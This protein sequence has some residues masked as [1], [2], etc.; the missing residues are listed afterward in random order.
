MIEPDVVEKLKTFKNSE[1]EILSVYLGEDT[2]QA[3]TGDYLKKQFH[4]LLH[5]N[6]DKDLR[7]KFGDDINS[8]EEYLK[9]YTPSG[10]T[11]VFFSAG[12]N[13]WEVVKLEFSLPSDISLDNSPNIVPIVDALNKYSKYL[14]LLTDR[15]KTRMLLVEQGE[16]VDYSQ[17]I[18]SYVPQ[19]ESATGKGSLPSQIDVNFRHTEKLLDDRLKL[20]ADAVAKF[21]KDKDIHF[22]ILGGHKEMFKRV[23]ETLKSDLQ[24]KIV[25][26]FVSEVDLPLNQIL[27][28]SKS[29]AV[30]I[31]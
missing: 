22:I 30:K 28:K 23:A 10:R 27:F 4:S 1:F 15:E 7:A 16:I 2:V 18:G 3:P 21:V 17:F 19:R 9:D 26:N 25:G 14:V 12:D 29:V 24:S 5:Q 13:L 8:I 31:N 11:L 20:S 6:L